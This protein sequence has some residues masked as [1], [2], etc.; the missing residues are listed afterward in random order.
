MASVP[1]TLQIANQVMVKAFRP[2]AFA[3]RKKFQGRRPGKLLIGGMRW[4]YH[5]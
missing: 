5:G 4:A 2:L 1:H 3:T